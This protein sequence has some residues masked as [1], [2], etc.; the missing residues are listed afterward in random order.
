MKAKGGTRDRELEVLVDR[1]LL[2][3]GHPEL[4]GSFSVSWH[5]RLRTTAGLA[6]YQK[7]AILL[8]P[9][10]REVGD[11]EIDRTLRHELAHL[12]AASRHP[13]RRLAPHGPEWRQA[14]AD[15]GI[16]GEDRCHALPW[17]RRQQRRKFFYQCPVCGVVV[18]RVRELRGRSACLSCCRHFNGGRYDERFRFRRVTDQPPEGL[19]HKC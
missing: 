13:H 12:L 7:R 8:N 18:A 14:C 5:G 1:L 15:L 6:N 2:Q 17:T 19:F 9:A 3:A 10:L 16:P 11:E 4:C